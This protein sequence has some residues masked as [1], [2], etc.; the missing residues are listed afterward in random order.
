M[1][2]AIQEQLKACVDYLAEQGHLKPGAAV[3]LGCST[4]E[5]AGGRIGKN[6]VPELGDALAEAMISAC[7]ARAEPG[8]SVLRASEP[9][10]GDGAEGAG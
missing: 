2:E 10:A 7:Q 4:S 8:L 1:Y 5:V 6:S 3:V 9:G